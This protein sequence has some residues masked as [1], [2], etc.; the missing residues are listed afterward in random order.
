MSTWTNDEE[1]GN[2][3]SGTYDNTTFAYDSST[4]NYNGQLLTIWTNDTE[5]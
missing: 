4:Y 1:L 2:A 3:T 5:S